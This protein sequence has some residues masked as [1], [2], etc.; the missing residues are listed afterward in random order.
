MPRPLHAFAPVL[1]LFLAAP[2]PAR[3]ESPCGAGLVQL[4]GPRAQA[5]FAPGADRLAAV[6]KLP[7]GTSAEALG[8]EPLVSGFARL[9]ATPSALVAF[10]GAHPEA[11]LELYPPLHT[12]LDKSGQWTGAFAAHTTK[13]VD[14][15]GVLVGV[16]D[17]GLDVS[18]PDLIDRATGKSRVAWLLDLSLKPVG[19]YPDLEQ[20]YGIKDAAGNVLAGAVLQG[21]DIDSLLAQKA[22]AP[23]DE[24]GHGT[25]VTSIAAGNGGDAATYVG[26]APKATIVFARVTRDSSDSIN[27]DD[28]LSGVGFIFDRADAIGKPVSVNLSL[29]SD[30]GPH[31][32]SMSWEQVLAS[33]VGPAHPGHALSIAAG[34]SGSVVETPVH[35]SVHVVPGSTTRVPL[36]TQGAA[37]GQVQVWVAMRYGASLNVGLDGPDGTWISPV[38]E[39]T[40]QGKSAAGYNAGVY[41]GSSAPQ[42]PVPNGSHGAVVVWSGAWA[43]GVYTITL[44]GE[45]TADLFV[46]ATGDAAGS[47]GQ[48]VGF[49]YG[50]REGTINLPATHPGLIAVGCTV[51]RP[52]WVSIDHAQVGLTVPVLDQQGGLPDPSHATQSLVDGDVCWF[53]SAG[54]TLTGVPKPEIAAPGG[55]V[56]AAMSSQA[57]PG[58][59]NSIFS[60]ADC[61]PLQKGGTA[62]DPKCLQVDPTH[63]VSVGTSMSAPQVAGA[64]ALLF[65]RDPTLTQDKI[66][67]LLQAGA[68]QFRSGP[69]RFDDQGGP[70]ELDILGSLDAMDQLGQPSLQLP[71]LNTSWMTLS[72][73]YLAADGSTPLVAIVELRTE[74]GAHRADLFDSSRLQPVVRLDNQTLSTL[75]TLVRRAPGLWVFTI[76]PPPGLGGQSVTLGATFDGVDI[77]QEKTI[78]IAADTWTASYPSQASGSCSVASSGRR[79]QGPELSLLVAAVVL[80]VRRRRA[81]P[82]ACRS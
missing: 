14:G 81:R 65:Q 32:G 20:K 56:V 69:T 28:L 4:L 31:D 79:T 34:N 76:E 2:S 29:G 33:Y 7:P 68:H 6:A 13:G 80:G 46:E 3:A 42:S 47:G 50:V 75:P 66:V 39:G 54:P 23:Q 25:H 63:A 27:N 70:G 17:T 64:I 61:P 26:V 58:A 67:A 11:P 15:T 18:H 77:V 30:F 72:A 82:A 52:K 43:S 36:V 55:V 62:P 12:L 59:P 8:L 41:N 10:A 21:V 49:A 78:P 37:N 22:R 51:N 53:S 71:S 19:L 60:N 35:Q 9:H 1:L 57:A 38:S 74:D 40:Q 44:E 73:D 5:V 45:G 24:V 48:N 16:A